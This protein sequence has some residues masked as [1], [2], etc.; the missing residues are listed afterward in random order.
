MKPGA[1]TA[2]DFAR[3]APKEHASP[4]HGTYEV[5]EAF[6]DRGGRALC[7]GRKD[8]PG[9]FLDDD[10]RGTLIAD[11]R[12]LVGIARENYHTALTSLRMD[13]LVEK[14]EDL[15]WVVA[16][17]LDLAGAHVLSMVTTALKRKSA[18]LA[19][20]ATLG[21]RDLSKAE[22]MLSRVSS[23]QVDGLSKAAFARGDA[24]LKKAGKQAQN[25]QAL[26]AKDATVAYIDQLHNSCDAA[27]LG[28]ARHTSAT[29]DDAELVVMWLGMDPSLHTPGAYKTALAAKIERF[30]KSGVPE[31]GEGVVNDIARGVGREKRVVYVQDMHGHKVPWYQNGD[32][33]L[34]GVGDLV[35]RKEVLDGP[36]PDEFRDI[37]VARSEAVWGKTPVIDDG[38]SKTFHKEAP[39]EPT[40]V[41]EATMQAFSHYTD[42]SAPLPGNSALANGAPLQFSPMTFDP[43][44]KP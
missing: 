14:E 41:I 34:F 16:L 21:E 22:L 1:T 44:R 5:G 39:H 2:N 3:A 32:Q 23:G 30:K 29:A 20:V 19:R 38:Y 24:S 13:K 26:D 40:S 6:I 36:V 35:P 25:R 15:H 17:A 8:Q 4:K 37:A 33:D 9:C 31:I 18:G 12:E 10:Q 27:F 28:F 11:F 42:P 43:S 7:H